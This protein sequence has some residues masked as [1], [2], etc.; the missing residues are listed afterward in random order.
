MKGLV[1]PAHARA[2][3]WD[4]ILAGAALVAR[5]S[6]RPLVLCFSDGGDTSSWTHEKDALDLLT[7]TGLA[8]DSVETG[9]I[10]H[11]A[12]GRYGPRLWDDLSK[13]T[14][15]MMFEASASD[16]AVRLDARLNELRAGYILTFAPAGVKRG[17]G[18][19]KIKVELRNRKATVMARAG[20]YA[21]E[22]R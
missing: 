3:L 16:L 14:G 15:G 6:L 8:V 12:Y 11:G 13:A 9:A 22:A 19:H 7:G 4:A 2:R 10:A 21:G 5:D 17:D 18:F 20:Y 1:P